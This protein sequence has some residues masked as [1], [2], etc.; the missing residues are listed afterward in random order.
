MSLLL[1]KFSIKS[2]LLPAI[3][4]ISLAMSPAQHKNNIVMFGDSITYEG[5]WTES[6][7]RP[8][9]FNFG[10]SGD[11]TGTMKKNTNS[12]VQMQPKICFIMGGINDLA[13]NIPVKDIYENLITIALQLKSAGV[14]PV[15]QSTLFVSEKE[16]SMYKWN[17]NVGKL[18]KMVKEYC[19]RNSVE[20]LDL[21]AIFAREGTLLPEYTYDGLHLN[22]KAYSLWRE[23]VHKILIKYN[24]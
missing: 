12:I 14:I 3:F 10:I 7:G 4:T 1:M 20:F 16:F 19:L 8:D 18:N 17:P 23:E 6:L 24:I 22:E 9:V 15:L 5:N 2:V 11:I 13:L 21:N